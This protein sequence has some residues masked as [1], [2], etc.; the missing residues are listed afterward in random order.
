[1]ARFRITITNKD[2]KVCG[3]KDIT[4]NSV[5]LHAH[6]FVFFLHVIRDEVEAGQVKLPGID[7][8]RKQC[9]Q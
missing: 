8:E 2:E 7:R 4:D 5:R 1:M 9:H 3:K 6:V